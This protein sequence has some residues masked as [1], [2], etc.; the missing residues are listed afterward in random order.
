MIELAKQALD[1]GLFTND[2]DAMLSFW[3]QTA[4]VPFS[5]LLPLGGG[6]QQHRHAIGESVLKINHAR[7]PL[8]DAAPG[9]IRRLLIARD[10]L[11]EPVDLTDPDGNAVVLVPPG[12]DGIRQLR[13]ELVVNDLAAHRAFYGGALGLPALG[14][15]TW[16]CGV[17]QIRLI[18]GPATRDPEQQA[19]GYRYLTIQ[20]YDVK[21]VHAAILARGGREGR[22]P[23]RLGE[24]A[25]ISFVRDPDGNWLEI[26]QRKSLTGSLD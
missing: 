11:A 10:G 6:L 9:G 14:A 5:E 21:A 18:E 20:V 3:Q 1:V 12:H 25:H 7:A 26:S 17:S 22:P 13:I 19:R 15:D 24:V 8:P 16:G 23:V 4:G 2:R